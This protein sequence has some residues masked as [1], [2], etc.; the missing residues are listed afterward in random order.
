MPY[1]TNLHIKAYN[2]LVS[3]FT[4]WERNN[5]YTIANDNEQEFMRA[6]EGKNVF[7]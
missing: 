2:S 7:Y 1:K 3:V 6:K 5:K 4:G